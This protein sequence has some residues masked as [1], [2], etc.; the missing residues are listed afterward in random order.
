MSHDGAVLRAIAWRDLC[1]WLLLFRTF[2]LAIGMPLLI[3]ATM[4]TLA[5]PIGWRLA[6]LTFAPTTV[7]HAGAF[8][9]LVES[10]REWPNNRQSPLLSWTHG[11]LRET[12]LVRVYLRLVTPY[13]P[14][15]RWPLSGRVFGYLA[16]GNL[17]T[18]AVWALCG[19]A[20]VRVAIVQLGAEERV[21][22]GRSVAFAARRFGAY[23]AGPLLPLLGVGLLMLPLV[24]GGLLLRFGGLG[25]LL[26]GLGF[27]PL[28]LAAFGM[29]VL[30]IGL[31]LGWP[32]MWG[33]ISAEEVGDS[34][35]GLNRAYAF[36]FQRPLHYAFYVAVASLLGCVA[37]LFVSLFAEGVLHLAEWSLRCGAG[38]AIDV[39][40]AAWP[41]TS[42]M[43]LVGVRLMG[44][45]V[46]LV[47][48][49]AYSFQYSYFWCVT[50]AVYLLLRQTVDQTEFDEIYLEDDIEPRALPPFDTGSAAQEGEGS[51]EV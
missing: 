23:F 12:P 46:D 21:G 39:H 20:I 48:A 45:S 51:D 38:S 24:L 28:L 50:A 44:L 6:E 22:V 29:A 16:F 2:R 35:E 30:L 8:G 49:L 25:L 33:A 4:G 11:D 7:E 17:W 13:Q 41:T 34:F 36:S 37:W 32:L 19:G 9:A 14:L 26:V 40:A 47:H 27:L 43:G 10:N 5:T 18:L 42:S 1:P 31:A 15:F 3:V